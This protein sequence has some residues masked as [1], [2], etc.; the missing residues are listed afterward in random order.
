MEKLI[1]MH[2]CHHFGDML[3]GLFNHEI[4]TQMV[5]KKKTMKKEKNTI[6]PFMGVSCVII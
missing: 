5:N 6:K 3:L 1:I 4:I 2:K